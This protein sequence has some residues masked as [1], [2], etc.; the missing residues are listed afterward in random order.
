M[1]ECW[2]KQLNWSQER[3]CVGCLWRVLVNIDILQ[4]FLSNSF[5][6]W[7]SS[8]KVWNPRVQN[9]KRNSVNNCNCRPR[10]KWA[11]HR[12]EFL[13]FLSSGIS[14][15]DNLVQQRKE[16]ENFRRTL[17][18]RRSWENN[19]LYSVCCTPSER[20]DTE[21]NS[22]ADVTPPPDYR[23][24]QEQ[25]SVTFCVRLWLH[26]TSSIAVI[27]LHRRKTLANICTKRELWK[28]RDKG[29]TVFSSPPLSL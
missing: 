5:C 15:K 26:P 3:S 11:K 16:L 19:E 24:A 12:V 4:K 20:E 17:T 10:V 6:S 21:S 8:L 25:V 18:T 22:S 27:A 28:E 13:H 23:R 29:R 7:I 9:K 1:I 14:F 2:C